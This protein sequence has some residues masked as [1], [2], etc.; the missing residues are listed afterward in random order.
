MTTFAPGPNTAAL[1]AEKLD[2]YRVALDAQ[3]TGRRA[4]A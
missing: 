4:G 2:V 1:D 3:G